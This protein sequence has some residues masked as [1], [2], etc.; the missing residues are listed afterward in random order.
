MFNL[1]VQ[2][3]PN[4]N[5][6]K[7]RMHLGAALLRAQLFFVLETLLSIITEAQLQQIR[8]RKS[9]WEGKGGFH[10][11]WGILLNG[12]FKA[13]PKTN[14]FTQCFRSIHFFFLSA[15]LTKSSCNDH[16]Q[17]VTAYLRG[18]STD[19]QIN[20]KALFSTRW[21][22]V[23]GNTVWLPCFVPCVCLCPNNIGLGIKCSNITVWLV[24]ALAFSLPQW[25]MGVSY[26]NERAATEIKV[27][28][29]NINLAT[30]N[31]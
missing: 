26:D 21:I 15:T 7:V 12:R 14:F 13:H 24:V 25:H 23:M 22:F 16:V 3:K 10:G 11:I 30:N 4:H 28:D 9:A 6:M 18:S 19:K 31:F 2:G 1:C 8:P 17:S 20:E 27:L 5:R 29:M